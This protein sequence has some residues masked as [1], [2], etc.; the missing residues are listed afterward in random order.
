MIFVT[1][2]AQLPFDRLVKTVDDWAEERNIPDVFAQT[3][4]SSYHPKW[5]QAAN[6]LPPDEYE[7]KI[8]AADFIVGHAGMGTIITAMEHSKP[9]IVMPRQAVLGEHR[10]EHQLAT[11]K[12][13][14]SLQ[15][16]Y[17]ASDESELTQRLDC[18]FNNR[19][20]IKTGCN[21]S[22][23]SLKLIDIIQ[24]FIEH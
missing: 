7:K 5:I 11:L 12:R 10:N 6:F 22:A 4:K 17:A 2:G 24:N 1:V 8:Q 18:L 23:V 21:V 19:K 20:I 13:F 14:C 9:L 16:I 3:G 15:N